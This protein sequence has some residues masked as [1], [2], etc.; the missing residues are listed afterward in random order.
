MQ[1]PQTWPPRRWTLVFIAG[2]DVV[3]VPES[4]GRAFDQSGQARGQGV[5]VPPAVLRQGLPRRPVGG[6][7]HGPDGWADGV[8]RDVERQGG[9]PLGEAA[10]P[11]SREATGEAGQQV[12]PDGPNERRVRPG[13]SPVMVPAG[14][15]TPGRIRPGDDAINQ[16]RVISS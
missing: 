2:R 1:V 8:F 7:F 6:A 15:V 3:A 10:E 14:Q 5:S 12:L 9:D 16:E 11:A 13:S 4:P